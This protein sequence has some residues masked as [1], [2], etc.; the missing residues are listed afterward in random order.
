VVLI[1]APGGTGPG[2]RDRR[3]AGCSPLANRVGEASLPALPGRDQEHSPV[4]LSLGAAAIVRSGEGAIREV[5]LARSR[6][7]GP[8][9]E[10]AVDRR[11]LLRALRLGFTEL[12]VVSADQPIA[13]RDGGRTYVWMPLDLPRAAGPVRAPRTSTMNPDPDSEREATMPTP[14]S[15][16]A[17]APPGEADALAEAEALRQQ[18]QEALTRTSRLIAAMRQQRRQGRAVQAAVASLRKLQQ[19]GG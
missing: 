8:A 18:L 16:G 15:N 10:V 7:L 13:C 19:L 2:G 5:P 9:L 12:V 1:Q 14:D 17:T 3:T 11:Y 4:T 6:V